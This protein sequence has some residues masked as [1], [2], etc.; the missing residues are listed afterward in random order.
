MQITVP[1]KLGDRTKL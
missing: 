1:L